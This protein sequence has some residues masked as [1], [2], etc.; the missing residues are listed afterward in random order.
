M[1]AYLF[2][3]YLKILCCRVHWSC[4]YLTCYCIPL[5]INFCLCRCVNLVTFWPGPYSFFCVVTEIS[6]P[7][8]P[9]SA[10]DFSEISVTIWI[11]GERERYGGDSDVFS[12]SFCN[13]PRLRSR[14]RMRGGNNIQVL[15]WVPGEVVGRLTDTAPVFAGQGRY[16]SIWH[17]KDRTTVLSAIYH[18]AGGC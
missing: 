4:L 12:L 11:R 13:R 2:I 8:S 1:L 5:N 15:R 6:D 16:C 3:T 18:R 14:F 10:S 7:L 17:Q 9:L